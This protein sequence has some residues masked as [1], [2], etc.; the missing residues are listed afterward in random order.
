[1]LY[2]IRNTFFIHTYT[3][4][5]EAGLGDVDGKKNLE[6]GKKERD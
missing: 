1:M 4:G 6:K 3:I 5:G 2:R